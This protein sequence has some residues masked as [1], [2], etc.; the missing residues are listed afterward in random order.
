MPSSCLCVWRLFSLDAEFHIN[1]FCHSAH[2]WWC[3]TV[4]HVPSFLM[5]CQWKSLVLFCLY[6]V[7]LPY[8]WVSYPW[9]QPL[10]SWGWES[11]GPEGRLCIVLTILRNGRERASGFW[12]HVYVWRSLEPIPTD[13]K[14]NSSVVFFS[15]AAFKIFFL[16]LVVSCLPKMYLRVVIIWGGFSRDFFTFFC[17]LFTVFWFHLHA[18]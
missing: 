7:G 4:F 5:R 2:W 16:S 1:S 8:V 17:P 10:Q 6:T 18:C 11:V 15:L 12:Y 14:D 9:I 13:T 3:S